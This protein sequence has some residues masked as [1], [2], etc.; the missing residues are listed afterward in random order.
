M[1]EILQHLPEFIGNHTILVMAFVGLLVAVVSA[2]VG[3]LMRG[4]KEVTPAQLTFLINREDA[5]LIDV[6][7]QADFDKAHIPNARHVAMSQFDPENKDLTKAKDLPIAIYCKSG[8][9][10]DQAAKRLVKAGFKR[11]YVLGGGLGGWLQ[12]DMPVVRGR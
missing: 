4:Y 10:S 3:R 5:L 8:T 7:A 12:A 9:T 11:V 2:E 6:S 1:S